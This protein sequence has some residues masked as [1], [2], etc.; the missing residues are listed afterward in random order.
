MWFAPSFMGQ[1]RFFLLEAAFSISL[2][3]T[4]A[5]GFHSR[6]KGGMGLAEKSI[7]G[8][9]HTPIEDWVIARFCRLNET[10]CEGFP[11]LQPDL[12]YISLTISP[13]DMIYLPQHSFF[14]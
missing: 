4:V 11:K 9:V 7:T 1:A 12:L 14:T 13:F 10:L 8:V 6:I 5:S 3:I 2:L